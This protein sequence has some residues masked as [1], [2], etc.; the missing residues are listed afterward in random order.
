MV[1]KVFPD[2]PRPEATAI[3]RGAKVIAE[4]SKWYVYHSGSTGTS[5]SQFYGL[6]YGVHSKAHIRAAAKGGEIVSLLQP[7]QETA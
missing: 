1:A 2:P 5:P 7:L 6:H 4:S 3:T